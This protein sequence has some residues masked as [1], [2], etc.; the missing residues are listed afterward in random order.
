MDKLK[1]GSIHSLQFGKGL[2]MNMKK[3]QYDPV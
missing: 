1:T 2:M 3:T